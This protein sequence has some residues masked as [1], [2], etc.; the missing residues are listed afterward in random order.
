MV[1]Q[2]TTNLIHQQRSAEHC[3]AKVSNRHESFKNW[4]NKIVICEGYPALQK[5]KGRSVAKTRLLPTHCANNAQLRLHGIE[6]CTACIVLFPSILENSF[7]MLFIE[8]YYTPHSTGADPHTLV[9]ECVPTFA[10]NL[11]Y[12]TQ[13]HPV[14]SCT[15]G[16][17]SSRDCCSGSSRP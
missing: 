11:L 8:T 5:N 2:H 15:K 13:S 17:H 6:G 7:V 3:Q 12:R 16:C 10:H 9:T 14:W 1:K 4:S